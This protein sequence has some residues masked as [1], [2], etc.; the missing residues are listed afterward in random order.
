M[1]FHQIEFGSDAYRAECELRHRVLR[2]PLGLSLYDEDLS[3]ESTQMHFGWFEETKLVACAIAWALSPTEARI[4][5][6]AVDHQN[7]RRG[8]GRKL[9]QAVEGELAGRG[10]DHFVLHA[11]VVAVGFYEKLGYSRIG[12]E[13]SEIGLPHVKMEKWLTTARGSEADFRR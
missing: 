11:R 4:R 10:F 5:Q 12:S 6:M 1:I 2:V 8:C 7:Q 3:R 9:L 13:F